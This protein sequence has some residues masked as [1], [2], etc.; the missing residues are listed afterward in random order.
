[1]ESL[2]R[3]ALRWHAS[4]AWTSPTD[5]AESKFRIDDHYPL[6]PLLLLPRMLS[7]M[8]TIQGLLDEVWEYMKQLRFLSH[9]AILAKEKLSSVYDTSP[10]DFT[11]FLDL[12]KILREN[13]SKASINLCDRNTILDLLIHDASTHEFLSS[14][15]QTQA[16]TI[17]QHK[18]LQRPGSAASLLIQ[19][20]ELLDAP[21]TVVRR[22]D[23]EKYG[24]KDVLAKNPLVDPGN[25]V[26][27]FGFGTA[28]VMGL[29]FGSAHHDSVKDTPGNVRMCIRC[30][31]KAEMRWLDERTRTISKFGQ[32]WA[33]YENE[34][35][36]TCVCGGKWVRLRI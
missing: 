36:H 21:Q 19:T 4:R 20:D 31:S 13:V 28:T 2:I 9:L 24:D 7:T 26:N 25:K 18:I 22:A 30:G 23:P 35:E 12:L 14:L 32:R 29:N 33:N 15:L 11:H 1:M 6:L 5:N 17:A 16:S 27:M 34:W 8:I 3:E 10:L